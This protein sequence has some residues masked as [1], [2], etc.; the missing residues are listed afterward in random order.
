MKPINLKS[1][2]PPKASAIASLA[3]FF[4]SS[5]ATAE[6]LHTEDWESKTP[7]IPFGATTYPDWTGMLEGN[8]GRAPISDW[9]VKD[10]GGLDWVGRDGA[11]IDGG[12]QHLFM[13]AF[14]N[15]TGR[16]FWNFAGGNQANALP[17]DIGEPTSIYIRFTFAYA[18]IL[19]PFSDD[20]AN[21]E[22][23]F[24]I[25]RFNGSWSFL[26]SVKSKSTAYLPAGSTQDKFFLE[27]R[28]DENGPDT[29]Q[30]TLVLGDVAELN[31]TYMVVTRYD[32]D[33]L[34]VLIG[35]ASWIDPV[36]DDK[37]TPQLV[38]SLRPGD[39]YDTFVNPLITVD[40]TTYH[41]EIRYDNLVI[42]TSWEAVVPTAGDV[43]MWGDYAIQTIDGRE[44]VDTAN[45][46]GWLEVSFRESGWIYSSS[47]GHWVY[48]TEA[49]SASG[50]WVYVLK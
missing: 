38:T 6:V 45:W 44:W 43:A 37:E 49:P 11:R 42:A 9:M 22:G 4:V 41:G 13:R 7:N 24:W 19:D 1:I 2:T 34:G 46:M 48:I 16:A 27:L 47:L 5:F 8:S 10:G 36:L 25:W 21:T 35:I 20:P 30:Q 28:R 31:R 3:L 50:G 18:T 39:R 29:P 23:T 14:N 15:N 33:D 12:E 40:L 32:F 17:T 26:N